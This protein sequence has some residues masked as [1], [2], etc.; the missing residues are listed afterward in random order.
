M[1]L[2]IDL[3]A[4]QQAGSDASGAAL[5]LVQQLIRTAGEHTVWVALSNQFPQQLRALR[6]SFAASLAAERIVVYDTPAPDGSAR[7][8]AAIALIRENALANLEPD[9]VFAPDGIERPGTLGTLTP[10]DGATSVVGKIDGA[11]ALWQAFAQ[12]V[13][14]RRAAP[15]PHGLP[16]LAYV[17]APGHVDLPLVAQLARHYRVELVGGAHAHALPDGAPAVTL[18]DGAWFEQHGAGFTRIVYQ[19]GN[20]AAHG[21]MP[22]LCARHPGLVLLDDVHLGQLFDGAGPHAFSAALLASHGYPALLARQRGGH[23]E[24]L[25][26]FPAGWPLLEQACGVIVRSEAMRE[27]G[28]H[29]YGAASDG[30]RV[31]ADAA[32]TGLASWLDAIE[33]SC[34]HSPRARYRALTAALGALGLPRDPRS[35]L[36]LETAQAIAANQPS[37]APR[38]LLVDISALAESDLRTGIQRVVRSIVLALLKTP[39]RG[40]RVEPV[41]GNGGERRYRYARRYTCNM[42]GET[43]LAHDAA[44]EDLPVEHRPGDIFLGLDLVAHCTTQN[45]ALL[46][47]MRQHGIAVYFVV[48]DLLPLLMPASFPYG[49]EVYFREYLETIA[50]LGDGLVC[51]SR[52]VA[53]ELCDWLTQHRAP[54]AAPLRI[55]F[56]HMGADL[57]SSAPSSGLPDNAAEVLAAVAARPTL[58]MVGTLEPRKGHVQALAAFE[59]LW[60]RGVDVNL[61]LVGK[62]GWLVDKLVRQM[63]RH[64]ELHRR[65]FWL[66]GASDEMLGKLYASASGLLAA[67][68]GEGFGLPLIES[69][70]HQLPIVARNLTVFREIGGEHAYYFDGEQPEQL[71]AAL[72]R[73]LEMLHNGTVPPSSAMP[74]LSWARSAEQLLATIVQQRWYRTLPV[75]RGNNER[76]TGSRGRVGSRCLVCYNAPFVNNLVLPCAVAP[77]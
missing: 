7:L 38:Q 20:S 70:Q 41:Y 48:Y 19:V 51:I 5:T 52:A 1:R 16:P 59:L 27:Q 71:A 55:G 14:A 28:R 13:P 30:W 76:C 37:L 11:T 9:L 26:Q 33:T 72:E 8:A 2:V 22:A 66:Q 53:D 12:A 23:A 57:A 31:L 25:R 73:W 74:W 32:D 18:R 10:H 15:Q 49:T 75:L 24:A 50:E 47:D 39:P 40:F 46:A 45:R 6:A 3:H 42:L 64:P 58:L 29:W 61:V 60:A 43:A 35:P 77:P 56:F 67:S 4:C 17:A 36:L 34:M 69:A 62:A 21:F 44:L 65:L 68:V 54:A 63:E